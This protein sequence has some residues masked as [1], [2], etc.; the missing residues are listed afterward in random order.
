MDVSALPPGA[1]GFVQG[2][3]AAQ[4][5]GAQA[6]QMALQSQTLQQ[7]FE[8]QA[9]LTKAKEIIASEKDPEKVIP[10]LLQLGP[11]GAQM[12]Q[13]YASAIKSAQDVATQKQLTDLGGGRENMQDPDYLRR[14][15][16]LL[17]R[18][19]FNV[20]AERI[21]RRKA[22]SAALST[23][24]DQPVDMPAGAAVPNTG[25]ETTQA[26]PADERAAFDRVAAASAQG[27]TATF[28]PQAG[29]V[30]PK[31]GG[32]FST[33]AQSPIP[34]IANQAKVLQS[35]LEQSGTAIPAQHWQDLQ[36]RLA[37]Q[38]ASYLQQQGRPQTPLGRVNADI[39]SGA[40]TPAQ[41]PIAVDKASGKA[42][43]ANLSPDAVKAASARYRIDGSLPPGLGRGTQGAVNT[44]LILDQAAKDAAADGDSPEASRLTQISNRASQQAL[45]QLVKQKNLILAFEK[46]AEAN[47]KLVMQESEKV[48]RLGSPVIDRWLQAGQKNIAGDVAV[49]RLDT[50]VRTF[51]NEYARV[52]TS[53]TG[54]GV[55]SDTARKEVETLLRSAHTKEQVRGVIDLMTTELQNRKVAYEQQEAELKGGIRAGGSSGE[56]AAQAPAAPAAAPQYPTATAPNGRKVMFKDGKWQNLAP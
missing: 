44:A 14:A 3:Q 33:L 56:P 11:A 50:A 1:A 24:R 41:A 26:I 10:A 40:I 35:R 28:S 20:E 2:Q 32:L 27:Q 23:M 30:T 51:V 47:A 21:E 39:K 16:L 19:E 37:S 54:G 45:G 34:A 12:A 53:V 5:Q 8:Q 49:A 43:E 29:D 48:D 4:Q 31:A 15:A 36:A 9:A 46:N 55:T 38:E 42:P 17:K 7:H 25:M 13:H 6:M 52:T 18:P 22:N